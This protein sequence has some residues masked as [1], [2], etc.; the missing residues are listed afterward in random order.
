MIRSV[1]ST[2]FKAISRAA[3][4]LSSSTYSLALLKSRIAVRVQT[5]FILAGLSLDQYP[6]SLT[7][8]GLSC[9]RRRLPFRCRQRLPPLLDGTHCSR[10][11]LVKPSGTSIQLPADGSG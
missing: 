4:R 5:A 9:D 6:S 10:A 2:I 3:W 1:A 7:T 8:L 11:A